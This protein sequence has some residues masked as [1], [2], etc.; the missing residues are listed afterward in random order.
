VD[1]RKRL[2]LGRIRY[3]ISQFADV[4]EMAEIMENVERVLEHCTTT[5]SS[6]HSKKA[7]GE[8]KKKNKR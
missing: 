8:A 3:W 6:V 1:V 7:P 4:L 2:D 5:R